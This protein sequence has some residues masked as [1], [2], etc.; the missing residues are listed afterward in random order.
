M[1]TRIYGTAWANDADLA[2]T[3]CTSLEEA[4]KRDHTQAGARDGSL[5]FPGGGPRRRLLARQGLDACSSSS[6]TTCAGA[7]AEDYEEVNAPQILDRALWETSGHWG[8]YRENMFITKTE[9]ERVF[10]IKPMKLPPAHVQIF[11]HG[12]KRVIAICLCAWRNSAPFRA[13]EPSGAAARSDAR[14][15]LHAG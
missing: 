11:K 6:P 2:R 15:R 5:P 10:A 4:E 8:W 12:L 7:L 9:D 14:A 13:N 1:L 3:I